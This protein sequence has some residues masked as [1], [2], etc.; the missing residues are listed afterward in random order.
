LI[1]TGDS[2]QGIILEDFLHLGDQNEVFFFQRNKQGKKITDITISFLD[3]ES[4]G[5]ME[6]LKI[7]EPH[8]FHVP[9]LRPARVIDSVLKDLILDVA[10]RLEPKTRDLRT[11]Q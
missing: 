11:R 2:D 3:L 8:I 9:L 10:K 7:C 4:L 1:P 5:R 6:K